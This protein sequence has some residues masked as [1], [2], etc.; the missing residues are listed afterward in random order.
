[1]LVALALVGLLSV[2]LVTHAGAAPT[3]SPVSTSPVKTIVTPPAEP[4]EVGT[5]TLVRSDSGIAF[6]LQTTGL[7]TG[8]AVTVWWMVVNPGAAAPSVLYAAGHVVDDSGAVGFGGA[9]QEGDTDGVVELPGLSLAG[10]LDATGATVVLVVRDHGPARAAIVGQQLHTVD[11]CNPTCADLQ[12]SVHAPAGSAAG[13]R[14]SG[15]SRPPSSWPT[16]LTHA[17]GTLPSWSV[18]DDPA[19]A[20][21]R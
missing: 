1:M 7:P 11:V 20:R 6:S 18:K 12:L 2:V 3:T 21:E 16:R 8:H 4:V 10:L 17:I 9:L 14:A 15:S 13:W 5:S 19:P